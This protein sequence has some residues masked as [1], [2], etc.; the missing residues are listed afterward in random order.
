MTTERISTMTDRDEIRI[1]V[2]GKGFGSEDFICMEAVR[3]WAA[4]FV[5][6]YVIR[7]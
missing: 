3:L 1:M 2:T 6:F 5:S 7:I 4:Y